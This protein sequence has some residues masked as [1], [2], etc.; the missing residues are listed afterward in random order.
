MCDLYLNFTKQ[1]P[2]QP[3]LPEHIS[4]KSSVILSLVMSQ[5]TGMLVLGLDVSTTW[6]SLALVMKAKSLALD[7]A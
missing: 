2:I 1:V 5:I 7:L 6:K 3:N 4:Y